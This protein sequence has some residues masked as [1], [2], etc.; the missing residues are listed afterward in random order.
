MKLRTK[1]YRMAHLRHRVVLLLGHKGASET[2]AGDIEA[3]V[4]DVAAGKTARDETI[5]H[6][7]ASTAELR[8]S[9]SVTAMR[10]ASNFAN[11]SLLTIAGGKIILR[12]VGSKEA[13]RWTR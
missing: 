11:A 12:T 6:G 9:K 10:A 2:D 4:A 8:A 5:D 3:F 13:R 1:T 7:S